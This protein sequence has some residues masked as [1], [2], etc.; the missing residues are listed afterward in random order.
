[1]TYI[2]PLS[3]RPREGLATSWESLA[4]RENYIPQL[5]DKW[6]LVVAR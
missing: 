3:H 6:L 4:V 1:M 2:L 5:V